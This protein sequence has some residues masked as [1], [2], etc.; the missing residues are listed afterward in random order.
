MTLVVLVDCVPVEQAL[1]AAGVDTAPIDVLA[2]SGAGELASEL[3]TALGARIRDVL[4][5]RDIMREAVPIARE[6]FV[7]FTA[8]WSARPSAFGRDFRD[9]FRRDGRSAWWFTDLSQK[10]AGTR[11]TF[12]RLCELEAL[13]LVLARRSYRRAVVVGRDR[14]QG[15][16]LAQACACANVTAAVRP[17]PTM[18]DGDGFLKLWLGRA[19]RLALDVA[20]TLLARRHRL[21]AAVGVDA[22]RR[23]LA[24]CTSF[25]SQWRPWNGVLRDRYY[26]DLPDVI[27]QKT[28]WQAFYAC[29]VPAPSLRA[30]RSN[31]SAAARFALNEPDALTFLERWSSV[32]DVCRIYADVRSA[33]KYWWLESFDRRFRQSFTWD[34]IDIFPLVRHDLRASL[35]RDLPYFELLAHRVRHMISHVR[36]SDLVVML[37]TFPHG[38]AVIWGAR[39]ANAGVRIVG[40]QHSVASANQ[41][42]Y[43]FMPAELPDM[44]LP[45][46]FLLYGANAM[47]MLRASGVPERRLVVT[48]A[49]R[50]DSL[51]ECRRRRRDEF[52]EL[53][54]PWSA[55]DRTRIVL[56]ATNFWAEMSRKLVRMCVQALADRPDTL[57]IVK[58]HPNHRVTEEEVRLPAGARARVVV[59]DSDLNELQA[60]ADVMVGAIGTSDAEALAIG[61]PVVRV[62]LTHFDLSPTS[63]QPGASSEVATADELREA[64]ERV[65]VGGVAADQV[66][67]LVESAFFRLDGLA[68]ERVLAALAALDPSPA[69]ASA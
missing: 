17:R 3:V 52:A 8:E 58:P 1:A 9:A 38:R 66:D 18:T 27:Q 62:A 16:V 63:D 11:P 64:V 33:L 37:E 6:K 31:A 35:V 59:V 5:T 60:A 4:S 26:V 48:G 34:G 36:P 19:K 29:E 22:G 15:R 20:A 14:D 21:P 12:S 24:F 23:S 7:R 67:G 45:D 41:L 57:V 39:R 68:G 61:C 53:R 40:F 69:T 32:W 44:P 42:M 10:N 55:G 65:L 47:R 46:V 13:R 56:V 51:I 50:F 43:R 2:F 28:P 49:R 54:R 30:L 25:P